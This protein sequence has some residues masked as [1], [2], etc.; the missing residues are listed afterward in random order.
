M[1]LQ[2]SP[3]EEQ[4][5]VL[6]RAKAKRKISELR[7]I[8]YDT[9][10]LSTPHR[11]LDSSVTGVIAVLNDKLKAAKKGRIERISPRGRGNVGVYQLKRR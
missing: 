8:Y 1:T 10:A 9:Y 3:R 5:Y 6:F 11:A 2:L 4:I 7:Q